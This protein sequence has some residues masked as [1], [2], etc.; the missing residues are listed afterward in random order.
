MTETDEVPEVEANNESQ[1]AEEKV[2]T[3]APLVPATPVAQQIELKA[4]IGKDMKKF[5]T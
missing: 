2:Y 4:E 1:V 5:S 3:P